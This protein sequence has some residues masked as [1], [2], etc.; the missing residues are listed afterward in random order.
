MVMELQMYRD[1]NWIP[2]SLLYLSRAFDTLEAGEYYD[3]LIPTTMVA[4]LPFDQFPDTPQYYASNL[5]TN[6]DYGYVYSRYLSVNVLSLNRIE[7]ATEA[8]RKY[9]LDLWGKL[10]LAKT[11]EE[12]RELVRADKG[13]MEA[14]KSMYAANIAPEERTL[15]EAHRRYVGLVRDLERQNAEDKEALA[16][17]HRKYEEVKRDLERRNTEDE[18]ALAEAHEELGR[19]RSELEEALRANEELK[20]KLQAVEKQNI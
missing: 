12:V 15:Y 11:W 1:R 19:T 4:I 6:S 5:L 3:R 9:G 2:R 13:I 14:A 20:R 17:A 18:K 10:L 7:L 8:D 16:E